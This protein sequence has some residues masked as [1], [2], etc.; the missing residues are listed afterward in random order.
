MLAK[1][2]RLLAPASWPNAEC[3]PGAEQYRGKSGGEEKSLH[4]RIPFRAGGKWR[5]DALNSPL[6]AWP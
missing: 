5:V 6:S 2:R 3:Q 1:V 4:G